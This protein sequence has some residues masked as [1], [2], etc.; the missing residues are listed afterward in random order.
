M[1]CS[2]FFDSISFHVLQFLSWYPFWR[3]MIVLKRQGN[4]RVWFLMLGRCLSCQY[5]FSFEIPVLSRI[6]CLGP[7]SETITPRYLKLSTASY[8]CDSTMMFCWMQFELLVIS[9]YALT[10]MLN[11]CDVLSR[12][13]TR[14]GQFILSTPQVISV[15]YKVY[16]RDGSATNA[17][18]SFMVFF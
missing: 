2:G 15:I 3:S 18:G 8:F 11:T 6:S 5:V 9:F 14:S 7:F 4:S 1:R 12:C 16:V 13:S 17:D 10:F